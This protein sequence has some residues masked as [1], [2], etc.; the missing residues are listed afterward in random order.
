MMLWECDIDGDIDSEGTEQ[1]IEDF[2]E[3]EKNPKCLRFEVLSV[4]TKGVTVSF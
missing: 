4:C 1:A 3:N 2:D